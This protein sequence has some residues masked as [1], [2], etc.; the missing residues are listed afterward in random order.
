MNLLF[1]GFGTE[2]VAG[3]VPRVASELPSGR[4][5][6]I[7][8]NL[9]DHIEAAGEN[10]M[11]IDHQAAL[12]LATDTMPPVG[13]DAPTGDLLSL[14]TSL[15][16]TVLK[17]M[18]RLDRYGPSLSYA[19]REAAYR[20]Q[21]VYWSEFLRQYDIGGYVGSNI[22]HEVTDMVIAELCRALGIPQLIFYQWTPDIVLPLGDYRELPDLMTRPAQ[23]PD[24]SDRDLVARVLSRIEDQQRGAAPPKPF[25][26]QADRIKRQRRKR[27]RHW[28]LRAQKKVLANW[29]SLFTRSGFRYALYMLVEKPILLP[30]RD[31]RYL[32][33]Y[34]S[35]A[36]PA[37]ALDLPYVYLALHYQPEATTS[38]LG[39][40]FVEQYLMV[41]LLLAGLPEEV[42]VYVKEHPNQRTIGRGEEYFH[43]FSSSPRVR[44][45]GMQVSSAD[46]LEHALAVATVSGTVGFEA[47]WKGRPVLLFGE[48]YYGEGPG[49]YRIRDVADVRRAVDA[50][51]GL[52]REVS[53][54]EAQSFTRKL[55]ERV[56]PANIDTY[57][58][59]NSVEGL[60]AEHNMRVLKAEILARFTSPAPRRPEDPAG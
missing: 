10:L 19:R 29:Q 57:Y 44:F 1:H 24:A 41:D 46:L 27:E 37:P 54:G 48:T 14:Y 31:D 53:A 30:R 5:F 33:D 17:M 18:D 2:A 60:S 7:R 23:T 4:H 12:T 6:W 25:Y 55:L 39:G 59:D 38:P 28:I 26:M 50:L 16:P 58:H 20:R 47:I 45:V 40:P 9:G 52:E 3:L 13:S 35:R 49:V 36:D 21:F 11:V 32:A 8:D 51:P 42:F 34:R 56:L 43:L 15:K 22:P